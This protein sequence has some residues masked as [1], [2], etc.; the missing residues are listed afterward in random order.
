ML[1]SAYVP[2]WPEG[3]IF[4]LSAPAGTGKTTLA[5]RLVEQFEALVQIPTLTTRKMRPG[6]TAGKDYLFVSKEEFLDRLKA[7]ELV[8]HV[9][10]HG[11]LYG[12]SSIYVDAARYD[13]KHI[14]LVIDTDGAHSVKSRYSDSVLIFLKPPSMEELSR[15]L[16]DRG[17]EDQTVREQRLYRAQKELEDEKIFN[18]SV[19][20]DT[21]DDA[22]NVLSS[23]I[24]AETHRLEEK[25]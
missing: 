24:I 4:V 7:D 22:L 8:E 21:F 25:K 6:E 23:I 11:H 15:R 5:K 10:L 1:N 16:E 3:K 19:V 12:V 17:T 18:Y 13:G 2:P 14:L 20:N 9:E